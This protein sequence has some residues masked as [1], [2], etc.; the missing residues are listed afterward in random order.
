[1]A[2]QSLSKEVRCHNVLFYKC[3][4]REATSI[5]ASKGIKDNKGITEGKGEQWINIQNKLFAV[6]FQ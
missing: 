3:F 1:M 2:G 5:N 6:E 4:Y